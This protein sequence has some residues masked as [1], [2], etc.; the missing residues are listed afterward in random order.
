M[1][2]H[3]A[4]DPEGLPQAPHGVRSTAQKAP[5]GEGGDATDLMERAFRQ[6]S[7][8]IGR[9]ILGKHVVQFEAFG[10]A[11]RDRAR[12]PKETAA[13]EAHDY[14]LPPYA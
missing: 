12:L 11:T 4:H 13:G 10:Q 14:P 9:G 1:G 5:V 3:L 8:S 6:R 7:T 2:L